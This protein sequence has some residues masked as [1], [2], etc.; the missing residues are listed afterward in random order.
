[1]FDL[2][3]TDSFKN[4]EGWIQEVREIASASI[5]LIL[6]GN[7]SDIGEREVSTETARTF[8][9]Q[10]GMEYIETS[11]K[12]GANVKEAFDEMTKA[13]YLKVKNGTIDVTQE[14]SGVKLGTE[15]DF[16]HNAPAPKKLTMA[17]S[18]G[19]KCLC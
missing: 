7:K 2:S 4:V 14:S 10:N 8:A 12:T 17:S 15:I 3:Q 5:T 18:Q 9:K 1:M 13:I 16:P 6:V 19:D 11:A